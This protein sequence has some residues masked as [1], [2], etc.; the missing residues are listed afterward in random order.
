[1]T[2]TQKQLQSMMPCDLLSTAKPDLSP[3]GLWWAERERAYLTRDCEANPLVK[4]LTCTEYIAY[5][6]RDPDQT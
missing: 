1:M 4:Y 6:Q 3:R 2:V 5:L